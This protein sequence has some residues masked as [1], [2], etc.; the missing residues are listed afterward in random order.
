VEPQATT[1]V[2]IPTY[3]EKENVQALVEAIE[4]VH[5]P[6]LRVL[7]VDDS[8]P[9]GTAEL[10]RKMAESRPWIKLL[11]RHGKMGIGS[12]YQEGF[13]TAIAENEVDILIE[14]DADEQHPPSALP[15]L[16]DAINQGADVALGSRYVPGGG[17]SG[18]SRIRRIVSR[19]ANV[20]S[21]FMLGLK[22]KDTTSGLRAYTRKSAVTIASA[23]LPAKGF[24]FQVA[25]L[26]LLKDEAKIAEVPYVFVARVA[27][28]SKLG[29][30]DM[31]RFFFVVASI[32]FSGRRMRSST[33]QN[34]N[35]GSL[36]GKTD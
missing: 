30:G 17:I 20:Y 24:E 9:D 26:Y 14:M 1:C 16:I 27:G 10:V 32:S 36:G 18:W 25:S 2:I 6:R 19:G 4:E 23:N 22:V 15:G 28:Q 3:N 8:S 35:M 34:R 31:V 7:F 12:A 5:I 11:V 33:E 29:F 21:R 13:K